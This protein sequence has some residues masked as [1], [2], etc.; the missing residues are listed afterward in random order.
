M[1]LALQ[2]LFITSILH[3]YN[4]NWSTMKINMTL[5]SLSL[6]GCAGINL[7]IQNLAEI[8]STI[9]EARPK[10]YNLG[11]GLDIA[12]DS[13]DAIGLANAQNP[14]S[15]FRAM[16]TQWL[17]GHHPKPTWNALADALES[18][19]VGLGDLAKQL[20]YKYCHS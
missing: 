15:C 20:R 6:S 2:L 8:Q 10:W 9:W 1:V 16:L 4:H 11:L 7:S 12:A 19:P 17:R 18:Q 3:V 13:L 14:D 5:C